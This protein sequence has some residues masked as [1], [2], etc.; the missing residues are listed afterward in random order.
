[1]T[2]KTEAMDLAKTPDELSAK[3]TH[4]ACEVLAPDTEHD[5]GVPLVDEGGASTAQR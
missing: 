4:G 3:A 5:F 2:D 1:M